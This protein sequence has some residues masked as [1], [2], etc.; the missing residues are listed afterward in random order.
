MQL[1][2]QFLFQ[3]HVQL[4]IIVSQEPCH[5]QYVLQDTIVVLVHLLPIVFH[6]PRVIIVPTDQFT[7]MQ[8][9]VL[10]VSIVHQ[11]ALHQLLALLA[12]IAQNKP[13]NYQQ[14]LHAQLEHFVLLKVVIMFPKVVHLDI[15]VQQVLPRISTV[16]LDIIAHR[17][18]QIIL[19]N[20]V[21]SVTIAL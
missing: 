7:Q 21:L 10:Q 19:Y 11:V 5:Q 18:H 15:I 14:T 2:A 17:V 13:V 9:L 3:I 6:V 16:Q 20:N 1:V 4:D 8:I 12:I